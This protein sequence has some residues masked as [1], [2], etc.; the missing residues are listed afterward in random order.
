MPQ[1]LWGWTDE[2]EFTAPPKKSK[3]PA[4]AEKVNPCL[5]VYGAGPEGAKCGTCVHLVKAYYSKV[6][7]K[8]DL[9]EL[10]HSATTDHRVRWPACG[11]YEEGEGQEY[12][13]R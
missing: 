8:C 13:A 7:Y 4:F 6:Y 5:A 1:T 11:K 10:S 2:G 3:K 9:R 12:H